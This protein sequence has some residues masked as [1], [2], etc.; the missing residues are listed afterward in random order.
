MRSRWAALGRFPRD[1]SGA[2]AVEMAL[3]LPFLLLLFLGVVNVADYLASQRRLATATAL[4]ADLVARNDTIVSRQDIDDYFVAAGLLLGPGQAQDMRIDVRALRKSG[5]V[6]SATPRWSRGSGSRQCPDPDLASLSDVIENQ[7]D[8]IVTVACMTYA[9][10]VAAFLGR[11]I[12][13]FASITL[14]EEVA[15][16]P[17]QSA[18][19]SCNDC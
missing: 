12:L 19:L 10:P 8:I 1:Q 5:G 6:L 18:R 15:A 3:T 14:S 11:S 7:R 9:P 4:V 16:V 17:R 13:G 2:A